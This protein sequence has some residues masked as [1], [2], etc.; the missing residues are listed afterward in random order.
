MLQASLILWIISTVSARWRDK[1][2]DALE[3]TP[4]RWSRHTRNWNPI[5]AVALNLDRDVIVRMSAPQ[6]SE[7]KAS[8]A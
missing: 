5:A 1:I 4:A 6:G 3:R 7:N 8:A 2:S